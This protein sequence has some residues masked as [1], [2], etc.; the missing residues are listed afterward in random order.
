MSLTKEI[1]DGEKSRLSEGIRNELHLYR[2][3]TFLRAYNWSAWLACRFL[4]DFKV[5]KRKFKGIEDAVTY[6]GFPENSLAKWLPE[7]VEQHA[8]GENHLLLCLPDLLLA[9]SPE[10]ME[11]DYT[12]WYDTIPLAVKE[13]HGRE[14]A[15][16]RGTEPSEP[17]PSPT[18]TSVMQRILSFPIESKSPVESMMFLADV[19]KCLASLI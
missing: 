4:H 10:T 19:K 8:K 16:E 15:D 1:V 12:V 5:N 11:R 6:I 9:D 13:R 17:T 3:G 2:E 7:G 14:P 18:L